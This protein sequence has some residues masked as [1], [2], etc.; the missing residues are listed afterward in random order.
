M[1]G[2]CSVNCWSNFLFTGG[3]CSLP[4]IHLGQN[5]GGGDEDNGD[6]PQKI[7]C[8]YCHTQWPQSSGVIVLSK[9]KLLFGAKRMYSV[10]IYEDLKNKASLCW[11]AKIRSTWPRVTPSIAQGKVAMYGL[12][13]EV[14]D[15]FIA[16]SLGVFHN[17]AE[18][19]WFVHFSVCV[20]IYVHIILQYLKSLLENIFSVYG[21]LYLLNRML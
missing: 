18:S 19:F 10:C 8:A 14:G 20:Y 2:P 12:F 9:L 6:L 7:P 11:E 5:Y 1:M 17:E 13:L 21:R 3:L 4:A 16:H 15:T